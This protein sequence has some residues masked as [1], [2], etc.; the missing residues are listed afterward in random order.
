MRIVEERAASSN[1]NAGEQETPN[2]T[3]RN[4]RADDNKLSFSALPQVPSKEYA[5]LS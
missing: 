5:A 2:L 1:M 4:P 3:E